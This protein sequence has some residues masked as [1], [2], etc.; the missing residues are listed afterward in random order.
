M[1]ARLA[2]VASGPE[3]QFRAPACASTHN[4]SSFASTLTPDCASE[5][6]LAGKRGA[7]QPASCSR[8][9]SDLLAVNVSDPTTLLSGANVDARSFPFIVRVKK[10][11]RARQHSSKAKAIRC[12]TVREL[13]FVAVCPSYRCFHVDGVAQRVCLGGE[14]R[15]TLGAIALCPLP[16]RK[17]EQAFFFRNN[18]ISRAGP[19]RTTCQQQRT[20]MAP[21][22]EGLLTSRPYIL[23]SI[24]VI[25][26]PRRIDG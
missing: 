11:R 16:T 6:F 5:T 10:F 13:S 23:V 24:L 22:R 12:R 7:R 3:A 4:L 26:Q 17:E 2:T 8:L 18:R 14:A 1:A 20:N 21:D 19:W 15:P 25:A 9:P